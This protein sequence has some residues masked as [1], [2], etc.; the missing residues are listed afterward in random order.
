MLMMIMTDGH[1][2]Q[3]QTIAITSSPSLTPP[4]HHHHHTPPPPPPP[5]LLLLL[6]LLLMLLGLADSM[7]NIVISIVAKPNTSTQMPTHCFRREAVI[8]TQFL[9]SVHFNFFAISFL[10]AACLL[11]S[12]EERGKIQLSEKTVLN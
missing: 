2:N 10:S 5:R 11:S 1:H 4:L 3:D 7:C 6:L 12:I 9:S 8:L